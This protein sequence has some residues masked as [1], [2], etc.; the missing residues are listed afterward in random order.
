MTYY[1]SKINLIIRKT[2]LELVR[3][4]SFSPRSSQTD[5]SK[6]DNSSLLVDRIV[7]ANKRFR[8]QDIYVIQ[9]MMQIFIYLVK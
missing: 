9:L 8:D 3:K 5:T 6:S 1:S 2:L 4:N 7:N